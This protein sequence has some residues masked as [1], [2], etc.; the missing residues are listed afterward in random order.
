MDH[1]DPVVPIG[2]KAFDMSL[3]VIASRLWCDKDNLQVLC[4]PC[5]KKKSA[6]EVGL[7][8]KAKRKNAKNT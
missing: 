7:R 2:E 1:I 6:D 8:R 5:H 4:K 3:D